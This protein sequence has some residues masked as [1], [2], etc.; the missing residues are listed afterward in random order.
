MASP[1]VD[2]LQ[3]ISNYISGRLQR[4]VRDLEASSAVD[5]NLFD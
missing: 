2:P 5:G 4:L 1:D 3:D